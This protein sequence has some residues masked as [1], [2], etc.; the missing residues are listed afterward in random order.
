MIGV[1][2]ISGTDE[3]SAVCSSPPKLTACP[4]LDT[5]RTIFDLRSATGDVGEMLDSSLLNFGDRRSF[6]VLLLVD[7][8]D[9]SLLGIVS[10][11]D[12]SKHL[13]SVPFRRFL[14]PEDSRLEGVSPGFFRA[15]DALGVA[16]LANRE[17]ISEVERCFDEDD[18]ALM[19][20]LLS[21]VVGFFHDDDFLGVASL[22][23]RELTAFEEDDDVILLP[24][25]DLISGLAGKT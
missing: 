8:K 5:G 19:L 23:N 6:Q 13:L 2:N 11:S 22:A 16:S 12:K 3:S 1:V 15:D 25:E 7:L 4:L 24:L 9:R 18:T 17:L 21:L 10:S 14:R 20:P